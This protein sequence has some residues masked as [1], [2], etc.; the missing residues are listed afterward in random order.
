M[1]LLNL[2][3][4]SKA[5]VS[6]V[7]LDGVT[8]GIQDTDKIGVIGV[9]GTGK[10][11]L[12][13]IA[14]GVLA[15]DEGQ[16]VK[17]NSVRIS[18]LTQNPVFDSEK[19]ILENVS[20]IIEGKSDHWDIS[21]EARARL[22]DFG[23]PDPD[24][25]PET[26]SGG[27][28]KRAALVAAVLTPCDLLILDEPTNHLDHGMIEW[29]EQYLR[30][31]RGAIL[32]VTH[33]RYFL[34]Q[35]TNCILEIDKGK[36]YRYEE[37]YSGYLKM[38]EQRMNYALAAERKA[39]ALYK[40]D[41]AW[42]QRGARARSTK[43]KAHI[44]RFE[45]LRD[46]E[47]IVEDRE[48]V[49]NSLPS[50]LGGKT[51]LLEDIAK[52]FGG[53]PLFSHFTYTFRKTDRIGIVGPNGCGKSTLLR[54]IVGQ[55]SVDAGSV[56][57]G[58]TVRIG[59][60][61]QENEALDE[62]ERVIDYI[63]DTAEYIRTSDGLITASAMCE[64]F[65]FDGEMQ[66]SLIG[67]LSGGEK[68]R[69]YL[70]KVLMSAPNVLILDEPTNDLDIQTLRIL[71]DYLD[72][73]SGI[74]LTV[75]HDR[76][77]LDRVVTRIFVFR[78]DGTLLQSEGGYTDYLM[79]MQE[80][81]LDVLTGKPS[82]GTRSGAGKQT[83]GD[84]GDAKDNLT[85]A[86]A[87]AARTRKRKKLSYKDQREYDGIEDEIAELEERSQKLDE[88]IAEAATQYTRLAELTEEKEA[89]DAKLEERMER[90]FELQEMIEALERDE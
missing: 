43:Q 42:I 80:R 84:D 5:F 13:A 75:S 32:M 44:Q 90:Y 87:Y 33:D 40:Q 36:T 64:Q 57:I 18:Y 66:Y 41:L 10:S 12:L 34:D 77:F 89:V 71:E 86:E 47:K 20:S 30:S 54:C 55:E 25:M 68:R 3:N 6:R 51:I 48:V 52:G 61:S 62:T 70:L 39:A 74:I 76:Y 53:D 63:R 21:G 38:K 14:A 83:P 8:V 65:L 7:L 50:R 85:G 72:R 82:T 46:R 67:K 78:E 11:T 23:I 28:K 9:N 35:V 58:Q 59:Y 37:N 4:V 79:H 69:L 29:L 81:G 16:V 49:L 19:T 73:F 24:V 31:F 2:E 26:L 45:A 17:R 27:Q 60:F 22:I 88:E 56:E 1:N 15:P